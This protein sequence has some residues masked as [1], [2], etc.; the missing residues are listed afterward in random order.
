MHWC[1]QR[2]SRARHHCSSRLG[3]SRQANGGNSYSIQVHEELAIRTFDNKRPGQSRHQQPH[4]IMVIKQ[5]LY[6]G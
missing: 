6:Y 5:A 1:K 2:L 4:Q 3:E